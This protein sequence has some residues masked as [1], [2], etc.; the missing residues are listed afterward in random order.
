M[1]KGSTSK[2]KEK[3]VSKSGLNSTSNLTDIVGASHSLP[4]KSSETITFDT[5]VKNRTAT[6]TSMLN[7]LPSTPSNILMAD[8]SPEDPMTAEKKNSEPA[9]GIQRQTSAGWF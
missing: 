7:K 6:A 8:T 1:F 4:E 3:V 9:K 5:T 2:D